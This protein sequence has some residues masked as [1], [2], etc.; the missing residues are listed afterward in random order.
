MILADEPTGALDNQSGQEIVDLLAELNTEGQTVI[1]VT[2]D[3]DIA[4]QCPCALTLADGQIV[5]F[6]KATDVNISLQVVTRL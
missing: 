4:A 6:R 5:D 3:D 1:I 2:H